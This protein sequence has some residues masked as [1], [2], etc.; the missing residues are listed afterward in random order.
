M[1]AFY[2]V[3]Q[4]LGGWRATG[5]GKSEAMG[6]NMRLD[7]LLVKRALAATR[8]QARQLIRAGRVRSGGRVLDKPGQP[9]PSDIAL[10][11]K[12]S[13]RFVSRGGIK[14]LGAINTFQLQVAGRIGL[15]AGISTGGFS[16]CLLQHGCRKIYGVDVGYGQLAWS[17][18]RDQR[19]VLKERCNVRYLTPRDLY[20]TDG[21][22]ATLAVADL[23]FISLKL[24][25]PTIH[26]LLKP[27]REAAVL[28]KPQ[29]EVGR[30]RVGKGGVVRDA[31]A[32]CDAITAVLATAHA[33]GWHG[34][35]LCASPITGPAGNHEY[36]LHLIDP[37]TTDPDT[38]TPPQVNHARIHHVVDEALRPPKGP[39]S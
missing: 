39:G 9:T 29:F 12:P 22:W 6:K 38:G 11:V 18:R 26:C 23:S 32:H 35:D 14:L 4:S 1:V 2:L 24:V 33:L 36:W 15:D 5:Y 10:E 17:L 8:E 20:G 27:P 3:C 25:M 28:V 7:L 13:A 19:V 30:E 37:D 16:D 34:Q 21:D 31:A